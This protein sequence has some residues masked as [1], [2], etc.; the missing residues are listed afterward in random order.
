MSVGSNYGH[1]LSP[2]GNYQMGRSCWLRDRRGCG[3]G[4]LQLLSVLIRER[5]LDHRAAILLQRG[6][7]LIRGRLLDDHEQRRGARLE[8]IADLLLE[9]L[10]EPLLPEVAKQGP[11]PGANCEPGERDE[12]EQPKEHAPEPAPPSPAASRC[13]AVAGVHVIFAL[14]VA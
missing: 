11:H 2:C 7:R 13:A 3:D 1:D 12:E 14:Q 4:F 5:G 10:V 6:G 9:R 8:V